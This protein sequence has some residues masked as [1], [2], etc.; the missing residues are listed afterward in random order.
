ML[1]VFVQCFVLHINIMKETSLELIKM[2]ISMSH[3]WTLLNIRYIHT[4]KFKLDLEWEIFAIMA[5]TCLN[6]VVF[7]SFWNF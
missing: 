7:F 1:I 4:L 2:N 3:D 6:I 5:Y